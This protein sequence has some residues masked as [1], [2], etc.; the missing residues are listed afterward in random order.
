MKLKM[1]AC[2]LLAA[3]LSGLT[4]NACRVPIRV[5]CPNDNTA[6]GIRITVYDLGVYIGEGVT[7]GLGVFEIEVPWILNT[8]TICV[9]PSTLPTGATIKKACQDVFVADSTVP[10][11]EF[12]LGGDFCGG[13]PPPG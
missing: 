1:I 13:T 12:V 10:V 6:S 3:A 9:D 4:A 8:Y 7:D 5:A 2:G 11:V